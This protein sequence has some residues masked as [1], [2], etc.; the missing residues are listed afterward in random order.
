MSALA[1]QRVVVRMLFDEHLV[2]RVY[3]DP[4]GA[5]PE[6]DLTDAERAWLVQPD[7][8]RWRADPLRRYRALQALLEEY[9]VAGALVIR[10]AGGVQA[11]DA[12]FSDPAFHRCIQDRGVLALSF[13]RWLAADFTVD[14]AAAARVELAL[15]RVRRA[16]EPGALPPL[17]AQGTVHT[18]PWIDAFVT[19]QAGLQRYLACRPVLAQGG[20]ALVLDGQQPLPPQPAVTGTATVLV[21]RSAQGAAVEESP[22]ALVQLLRW[23]QSPRTVAATVEWLAGHDLDPAE[24][25]ELLGD[26]ANDGLLLAGGAPTP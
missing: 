19:T 25:R 7:K 9:P 6:V 23:C 11:L 21:E 3:A 15:A 26:L 5:L 13:G 4:A 20:T 17:D 12:Y 16:A 14:V 18:A 1:L 10:E 8:R 2:D 24:A 22:A